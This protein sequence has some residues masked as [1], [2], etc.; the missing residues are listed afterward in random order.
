MTCFL[1][2]I[3]IYTLLI[4]N[5]CLSTFLKFRNDEVVQINNK[6]DIEFV[7]MIQIWFII[8]QTFL[9]WGKLSLISYIIVYIKKINTMQFVLNPPITRLYYAN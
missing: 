8:V 3:E 6:Y 1:E 9:K 5:H 4:N 7:L 2:I